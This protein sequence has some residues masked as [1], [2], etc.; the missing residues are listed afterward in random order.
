[1][2]YILKENSD[3]SVVTVRDVQVVLLEMMKDI[4]ELCR[5]NNIP[6]FLSGGS[7]LGAVRHGGFIPWDDDADF[8]MMKEDFMRFIEVMKK[9]DKYVFQCWYTDK[10][11]NVLIPGMKIRKKGTYLKEVNTL[12]SNRC[13]GYDG[14]DGVFIDIFVW[15]YATPNKWIDLPFRLANYVLMVPEIIADNVFHINPV[16][17]KQAIM[18]VADRYSRICEKKK[19]EYVGFDLTWVW[20]T[21]FKPFIFR[22]DDIFPPHYVKFEDTE[23]PIAN[24]PHEYLCTAIAPSYMTPPPEDKRVAKHIVD[25][26]L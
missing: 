20:K 9:Q 24:H 22:K 18:N 5:E 3:G 4:G 11:Y 15:D 12:L 23:F 6:Y 21:P 7:A 8:F 17:I 14:C 2:D 25:I 19:S 13:T 10:R 26:R 1:M 16:H